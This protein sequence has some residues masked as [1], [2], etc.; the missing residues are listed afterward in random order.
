MVG[1][2]L[3]VVLGVWCVVVAWPPG[4]TTNQQQK[5]TVKPQK[6]VKPQRLS[7]TMLTINWFFN[8]DAPSL[9]LP[10]EP[11]PPK[12]TTS[13]V[14]FFCSCV[15]VVVVVVLLWLWLCVVACVFLVYLCGA[16]WRAEPPRTVCRF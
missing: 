10:R 16:V 3:T 12:E 5:T 14:L 15:V 13:H 6:T 8:F 4:Q 11:D 2:G 1:C 7:E 9:P